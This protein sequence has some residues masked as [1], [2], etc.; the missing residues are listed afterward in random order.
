MAQKNFKDLNIDNLEGEHFFNCDGKVQIVKV[1]TTFGK[2]K[3]PFRI[4][5]AGIKISLQ[6]KWIVLHA[7]LLIQN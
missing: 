3:G 1:P 7:F 4:I 2:F 6:C 5:I